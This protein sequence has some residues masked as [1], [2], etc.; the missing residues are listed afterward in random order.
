M[1]GQRLFVGLVLGALAASAGCREPVDTARQEGFDGQHRH[2]ASE[3]WRRYQAA[4]EDPQRAA[5]QKPDQVLAALKLRRGER[6]ADV[7]AGTGYFSIPIAKAVG[8]TGRVYAVDVARQ[9]IEYI[10]ERARRE[11]LDH[12]VPILAPSNNPSLPE[13]GVDTILIA[14]T[15]HHLDDRASY[16]AL[17][18]QALADGGRMV[19]IDYVPKPRQE[20]GHGP[21]WEMQIPRR[22][23]DAEL[24]AA[25]FVPAKVHDFLPEQYFV[26]YRR[27]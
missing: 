3:E 13:G 15:Y 4:L 5:W 7:G 14:N 18:D 27:R 20:R 24:A 12:I 23:V 11:K 16:L 9:M 6:V 19:I 22:Q 8:P 2:R 10:C 1:Q 25:G 21:P 26:E 17:L